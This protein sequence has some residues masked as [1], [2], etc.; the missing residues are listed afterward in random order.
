MTKYFIQPLTVEQLSALQTAIISG[1]LQHTFSNLDANILAAKDHPNIA[2]TFAGQREALASAA[3]A[4]MDA[5]PT[6]QDFHGKEDELVRNMLATHQVLG[7]GTQAHQ[8]QY[9]R[10]AEHVQWNVGGLSPMPLP[11]PDAVKKLPTDPE[12]LEEYIYVTLA[13][14]FWDRFSWMT[15]DVLRKAPADR[16]EDLLAKLGDM[17]SVYG[18]DYAKHLKKWEGA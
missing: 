4:I 8:E 14:E 15:A 11:V 17:S 9:L 12:E 3:R 6:N 18:S 1:A 7:W 13:N 10:L 2:M 5:K 16:R